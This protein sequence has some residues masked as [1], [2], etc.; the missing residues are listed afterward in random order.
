MSFFIFWLK[1]AIQILTYKQSAAVTLS[2][3]VS[4]WSGSWPLKKL[5][6]LWFFFFYKLL[7]LF[8]YTQVFCHLCGEDSQGPSSTSTPEGHQ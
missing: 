3:T 8:I 6:F 7:L 2:P 1:Q 4:S 5:I